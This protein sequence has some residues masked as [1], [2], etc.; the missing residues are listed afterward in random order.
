MPARRRYKETKK[1]GDWA[2]MLSP[3]TRSAEAVRIK[4]DAPNVAAALD[5]IVSRCGVWEGSHGWTYFS[6]W[7]AEAYP[8][9]LRKAWPE[10]VSK[11]TQ[12]HI[13]AQVFPA[14]TERKAA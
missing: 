7:L 11:F 9:A 2:T 13:G 4:R 5:A 10:D 14:S 8:K 6:G 12:E 3:L 1:Q